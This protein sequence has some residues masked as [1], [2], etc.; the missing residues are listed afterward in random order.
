VRRRSEEEEEASRRAIK[1]TPAGHPRLP[2]QRQGKH[3]LS[4]RL[5][6]LLLQTIQIIMNYT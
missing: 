4:P 5:R 6:R 1:Q 3:H 2:R